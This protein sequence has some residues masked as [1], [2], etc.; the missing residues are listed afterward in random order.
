LK[1]KSKGPKL[2]YLNE[3]VCLGIIRSDNLKVLA[4]LKLEPVK[5]V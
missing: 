1:I 4:S 2:I 3:G 5:V